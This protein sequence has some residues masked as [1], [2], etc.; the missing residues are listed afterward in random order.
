MAGR[1]NSLGIPKTGR[2]KQQ[3][4]L[5]ANLQGLSYGQG[6]NKWKF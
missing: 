6:D 3:D 5:C 4:L 2:I 1:T